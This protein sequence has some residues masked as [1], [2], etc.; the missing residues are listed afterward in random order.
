MRRAGEFERLDAPVKIVETDSDDAD[1][2]RLGDGGKLSFS[3]S[4]A[5]CCLARSASLF[6]SSASATPALYNLLAI[7]LISNIIRCRHSPLF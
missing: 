6:A 7:L 5:S 4:S 3:D 2:R 1:L